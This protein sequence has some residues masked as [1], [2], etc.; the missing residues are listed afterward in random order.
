MDNQFSGLLFIGLI[1]IGIVF[2]HFNSIRKE[3]EF[4]KLGE[5]SL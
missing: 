5:S 1:V 3:K 2:Q 4:R